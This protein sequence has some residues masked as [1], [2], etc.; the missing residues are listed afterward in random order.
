M[1]ENTIKIA[2]VGQT[3]V[4][5]GDVRCQVPLVVK[6]K[7]EGDFIGTAL[8]V[9]PSGQLSGKIVADSI[10]CAGLIE[11]KITTRSFTLKKSAT[12]MGIVE[13]ERLEIEPGASLDCALQS[14][15]EYLVK[16]DREVGAGHSPSQKSSSSL[17]ELQHCFRED[18]PSCC[19]DVPDSF[20]FELFGHLIE[21]LDKHKPLIKITGD[22]GA[23]KTTLARK[24]LKSLGENYLPLQ[25]REPVGSVRHLLYQIAKELG[26][27]TVD[28]QQSQKDLLHDIGIS[29]SAKRDAGLQVL[30]LIDDAHLM[31]QATME[32]VVRLLSG[33]CSEDY[34]LNQRDRVLQIILFGTEALQGKMV[35]TINEYFEDETNCQLY[36]EPLNL[37]DCA[38]YL[39]LTVRRCA[40]W[41]CGDEMSIFSTETIKEIHVVSG[42]N[43]S[44]INALAEKGLQAAIRKGVASVVPEHIEKL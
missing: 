6:G 5:K 35:E 13:T 21:L 39:R 34:S 37:K 18:S 30:L 28:K 26:V 10:E 32:G 7:M 40:T 38:D 27:E 9:E 44:T 25:L 33:A 15:S 1:E 36:L 3:M 42:G 20:R 2:T 22:E 19:Y 43:I 41:D 23:G 14:G 8:R 17:C 31:Y 4:I 24:C 11:G 12:Q 29:I 16:G